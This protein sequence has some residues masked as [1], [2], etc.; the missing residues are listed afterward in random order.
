MQLNFLLIIKINLKKKFWSLFK[1][2]KDKAKSKRIIIIMIVL[3]REIKNYKLI[4]SKG[5]SKV[6]L[7]A[8]MMKLKM[9]MSQKK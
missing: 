3:N 7:I 5:K 1:Y 9:T 8:V 4:K 6:C 2:K